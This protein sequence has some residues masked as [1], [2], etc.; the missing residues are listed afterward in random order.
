VTYAKTR[1][2]PKPDP[3]I[4]ALPDDE[5][6]APRFTVVATAGA[7]KPGSEADQMAAW[8]R[9][10]PAPVAAS[11]L[12]ARFDISTDTLRRRRMQPEERGI[13]YGPAPWAGSNAHA[14]GTADQWATK[15]G[16][17]MGLGGVS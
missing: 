8:I 1:Q 7:V 13:A 16:E 3:V 5:D 15:Y 4:V 10:Q 9:E 2:G 12:T 11:L 14:Y 17:R 6:A